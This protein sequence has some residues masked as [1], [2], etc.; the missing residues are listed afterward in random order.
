MVDEPDPRAAVRHVSAGPEPRLLR[1]HSRAHAGSYL[2]ARVGAHDHRPG[3]VHLYSVD[4]GRAPV[5]LLRGV[6]A[7]GHAAVSGRAF[8]AL[9][10]LCPPVVSESAQNSA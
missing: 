5:F 10:R 6:R 8:L 2:V 9:P 1:A 7:S 4:W 3:A